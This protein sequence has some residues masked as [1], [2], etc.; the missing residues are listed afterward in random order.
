MDTYV[1]SNEV[2]WSEV[3]GG[4]LTLW[5]SAGSGEEQAET[6][7][8][9]QAPGQ[10]HRQQA[11]WG[12]DAQHRLALDETRALCQSHEQ[13]AEAEEDGA[14]DGVEGR[15]LQEV[16]HTCFRGASEALARMCAQA[17][18]GACASTCIDVGSHNKDSY[19]NDSHHNDFHNNES[20]NND[21]SQQ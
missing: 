12:V 1:P 20:R 14:G 7:H 9:A 21:V 16:L 11:Q 4:S 19:N 17:V 13:A 18:P 15:V 3:R 6:E 10:G 5:C 8:D 2:S